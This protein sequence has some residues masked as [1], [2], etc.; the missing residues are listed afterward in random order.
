MTD[1]RRVHCSELNTKYFVRRVLYCVSHRLS[2]RWITL[3]SYSDCQ[4]PPRR[5]VPLVHPS[6][7]SPPMAVCRQESHT[8]P[9]NVFS[10]VLFLPHLPL[11]ALQWHR[12]SA[13]T[14]PT[15]ASRILENNTQFW[16]ESKWDAFLFLHLWRTVLFPLSRYSPHLVAYPLLLLTFMVSDTVIPPQ[17][18]ASDFMAV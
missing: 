5:T 10:R 11:E 13:S 7:A 15:N 3:S 2:K 1:S 16:S 14:T 8:N 18:Q 9:V 4:T 17:V 12:F 6:P